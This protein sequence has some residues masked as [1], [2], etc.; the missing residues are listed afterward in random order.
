MKYFVNGSC[1]G[2]G[3]CAGICPEV[4]EVKNGVAVAAETVPA[5]KEASAKEAQESCPVSAIE[6][7]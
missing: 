3:M 5:G 7:R 2:C 1:I 6:Q 4:F